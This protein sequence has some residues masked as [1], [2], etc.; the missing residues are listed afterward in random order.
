MTPQRIDSLES[1]DADG[2]PLWVLLRGNPAA[3]RVLLLV[4]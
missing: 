4:Q 3:R 1:F 2:T